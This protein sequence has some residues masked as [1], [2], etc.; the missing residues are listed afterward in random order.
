[1]ND[2]EK[3]DAAVSL[4][5]SLKVGDTFLIGLTCAGRKEWI[6]REEK[7]T[8]IG[9]RTIR[10]YCFSESTERTLYLADFTPRGACPVTYPVPAPEKSEAEKLFDEPLLDRSIWVNGVEWKVFGARQT[11][12][13]ETISYR[14]RCV[15]CDLHERSFTKKDFIELSI[16]AAR[17]K[18]EREVELERRIMHFEREQAIQSAEVLRLRGALESMTISNDV[19]E[20]RVKELQEDAVRDLVDHQ[21]DK[22][23]VKELKDTLGGTESTLKQTEARV[24]ELGEE[25][26]KL[27]AGI[28]NAECELQSARE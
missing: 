22:E 4:F 12:E 1:V 14:S 23:R 6:V 20:S 18:T 10:C 5:G 28:Y 19:A 27:R 25:T 9:N 8:D 17:P 21:A 15:P 11:T 3:W 26:M 13:N 7:W 16:T 24:K 2:K